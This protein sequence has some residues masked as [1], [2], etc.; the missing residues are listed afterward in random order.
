MVSVSARHGPEQ[1]QRR[2]VH[3][4]ARAADHQ[5]PGRRRR[6]D[7]EAEEGQP[8]FDHDGGRDRERELHQHRPGDVRQ[9]RAQ[10]DARRR[11]AERAHRLDIVRGCA[12]T[13]PRHRR[14]ARSPA[15]RGPTAPGS[16]CRRRARAGS[17]PA[18]RAGSAGSTA[19][20][21]RCAP[22]SSSASPRNQ[23]PMQAEQRCR[24]SPAMQRRGEG[25]ERGWC[26][27]PRSGARARR[28]R[29]RRGRAGCAGAGAGEAPR[30]R[31]GGPGRAG[32]AAA[33]RARRGRSPR[34]A[35][36]AAAQERAS[37][38]LA[39]ADRARA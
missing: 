15:G 21:P 18:A 7:A 9:D 20:R 25:D 26:A 14:R 22:S 10:Q 33:P 31:P 37:C 34:P 28:G 39:R 23:P 24:R 38:A 27:R 6:H 30:R 17:R 29:T 8:A 1:Q 13:A 11:R 19:R 4:G 35:R 12:P 36:A 5:A 32:R 2:L 3:G 16:A